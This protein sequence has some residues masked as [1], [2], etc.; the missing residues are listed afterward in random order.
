MDDAPFVSGGKRFDDLSRDADCLV[1]RNGPFLEP[2]GERLPFDELHDDACPGADL[3][4]PVHVR[5]V[6]VVQRREKLRL[7]LQPREAV[8][9]VGNMFVKNLQRDIAEQ[10]RVART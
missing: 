5:D 8:G 10:L 6:G 7:A 1:G 9:I 2:V 3:L 4:Q